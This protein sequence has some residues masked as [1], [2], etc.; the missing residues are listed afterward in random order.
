[1][2]SAHV[3]ITSAATHTA[4]MQRGGQRCQGGLLS[5]R[6]AH[7]WCIFTRDGLFA[8]PGSRVGGGAAEDVP[9][10]NSKHAQHDLRVWCDVARCGEVWCGAVPQ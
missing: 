4:C 7:C 10:N 3:S 8:G 9:Q 5:S 6:E 2:Y 1:M